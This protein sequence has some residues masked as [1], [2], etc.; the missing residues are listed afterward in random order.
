MNTTY[1]IWVPLHRCLLSPQSTMARTI[2]PFSWFPEHETGNIY[3]WIGLICWFESF[4]KM[5]SFFYFM[6]LFE[7]P[8]LHSLVILLC[9][10]SQCFHLWIIYCK[11]SQTF[12]FV[13]NGYVTLCLI[14]RHKKVVTNI[15]WKCIL[16]AEYVIVKDLKKEERKNC[17]F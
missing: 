6:N 15:R 2:K 17:N 4:Y 13:I 3:E 1:N 7:K 8:V 5:L 9:N 14:N 16:E 10:R 11:V 12:A